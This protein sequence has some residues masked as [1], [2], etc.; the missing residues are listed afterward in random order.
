VENNDT[1][2]QAQDVGEISSSLL[3]ELWGNLGPGGYDGDDEDWYQFSVSQGADYCIV[4]HFFHADADLEME[5]LD[6][7]GTSLIGT[8][9][10]VDDDEEI[11]ATLAPG[12]YLV[13]LYRYSG[14]SANYWLSI[15]YP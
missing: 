11:T 1:A 14:G 4:A 7:T 13:R 3:P 8:S 10:S 5:L 2:I 6:F 15:L 12:T 9:Q